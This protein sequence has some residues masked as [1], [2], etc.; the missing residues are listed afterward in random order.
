MS[1]QSESDGHFSAACLYCNGSWT[2][3]E[4]F[5][6]SG[7]G[8]FKS[9][10]RKPPPEV[11]RGS[12]GLARHL[13]ASDQSTRW[14][15]AIKQEQDRSIVT[16]C[17]QVHVRLFLRDHAPDLIV[18]AVAKATCKKCL[19]SL[20][21]EVVGPK[22]RRPRDPVVL[23][24]RLGLF[25]SWSKRIVDG[26]PLNEYDIEAFRHLDGLLARSALDTVN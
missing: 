11:P 10:P 25:E 5:D 24:K 1:D 4:E 13:P 3:E 23:G 6:A 20:A 7:H 15:G 2:S 14:V 16:R 21:A 26:P 17:G 12:M 19:N 22:S 18:G 8:L 9:C